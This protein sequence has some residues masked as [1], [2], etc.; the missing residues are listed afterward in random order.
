MPSDHSPIELSL[1]I[2]T[3]KHNIDNT[4]LLPHKTYVWDD[5]GEVRFKHLMASP[6]TQ[7]FLADMQKCDSVNDYVQ[8]LTEFLQK[9]ASK[10]LTPKK[11]GTR[12]SISH[13]SK[14]CNTEHPE[15]SKAKAEFNRSWKK[16]KSYPNKDRHIEFIKLRSRYKRLKYLYFNYNKEDKL[17]KLAN[18]EAKDPKGF[19]RT[20]RSFTKKRVSDCNI[21]PKIWTD[22]FKNLFNVKSTNIDTAFLDYVKNSLPIIENVSTTGPLDHVIS[23]SEIIKS[24]KKLK[25]G[26]SGGPDGIINE[27]ITN[28]GVHLHAALG[29][30]YNKI[31]YK[32][33]YPTAWQYSTI[34]PVYKALN[35][36]EPTNYRG[37]AVADIMSK[38]FTSILNERLYDYFV[39]K[40]LWS[41]NQSGFM[42]KKQTNDNVFVL[43][44]IF[45]KYVQK[46]GKRLYVAFI[47]FSKFFD[48]INRDILK[49]KLLKY[50]ITGKFYEVIKSY[51]ANSYYA[52]KSNGGIAP[53]FEANNGVKQG[54]NLSPAMS[55]L[56][57][58]DIHAIFDESCGPL[59]LNDMKINSMSWA[60]DLVIMSD[61]QTGL[62]NCLNKLDTYCYK[63]GLSLNVKKT[64]FMIMSK[65]TVRN[66]GML[67]FRGESID[68]VTC[69]KYLGVQLSSNGKFTQMI[70]DRCTKAQKAIF[71]LRSALSTT[72][73][74]SRKLALTVFDKQIFP[75]LSYGSAIWGQTLN[76][77]TVS[78]TFGSPQS[79]S[80]KD[81]SNIFQNVTGN[82]ID[83]DII[84]TTNNI[85]ATIR[86]NDP[87]H[88]A[89]LLN[90]QNVGSA[91]FTVTE[92][93]SRAWK[94][95]EQ[96][97]TS[98]CKY[99]LGVS[100]YTSNY[101]T[102]CELGRVPIS[103]KIA[104]AQIL[105]WHR[106]EQMEDH[107]I[108]HHAYL[109]AKENNHEFIRGIKYFL[110]SNGLGHILHGAISYS[111][112]CVKSLVNMRLSDQFIQSLKSK[113]QNFQNLLLCKSFFPYQ[114]SEYLDQIKN[115]KIRNIFTRLRVNSNRLKAYSHTEDLI[116]S[117][118]K[119]P[120]TA[121][122]LLFS[123]AD[124][125]LPTIRDKFDRNI[126][127]VAPVF[128]TKT[129][130]DKLSML[131]SLNFSSEE[132]INI[133]CSFV[134]DMYI[135]RFT[136]NP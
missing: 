58:N 114:H 53:Y 130:D 41:K 131:L 71:Q 39:D 108:L 13:K 105:Y 85:R 1:S 106:L 59:A 34:T 117:H 20:I 84:R 124:G 78:I 8:A 76:I 109:E 19:W 18:I 118:C 129:T 17:Y 136:R 6:E 75:I 36:S 63:W 38:I 89:W 132:A 46:K 25:K 37:I 95:F 90:N 45:Q 97:H 30:L 42:K 23:H 62:Q 91:P 125:Q 121:S 68:Y 33:Q 123:C 43:H 133:A 56:Y 29:N 60:D 94:N 24:I 28:G 65:G 87:Q 22:Y 135:Y 55:N 51:Y 70:S 110:Q 116:C 47:D 119:V 115:V 40:G 4:P 10:C 80:K 44:T 7:S 16:L 111:P 99:V 79:L 54:C 77:D 14:T 73:N 61:S 2:N 127:K 72:Y 67:T 83:F 101:A 126:M 103:I 52:V 50:G 5:E 113:L 88:K 134:K 122:H 12:T 98:F 100:K 9:C 82:A 74:V 26:K 104:L 3:K 32:G 86:I 11:V 57:Q 120:E 102:L 81:L 48:V 96:I 31:L 15:L 64:K 35:P 92:C 69:Y 27:M 49:Y 21:T 107:S 128:G 93:S 66:S 112:R